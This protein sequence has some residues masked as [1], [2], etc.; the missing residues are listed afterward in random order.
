MEDVSD[1]SFRVICK[2]MGADIVYTEFIASEGIIRNAKK[3]N[4]K[5]IIDDQ[6]RPTAVQIFG[7]DFNAMIESA[8]IVE[9][10]GADILDINFGCWVKKVV[11]RE[12]GAAFLKDPERMAEL[13][14]KMADVV[15]IPLTVKT[16][17]GWD[18][19][20]IRINE[21]AKMIED[22]G[23]AALAIHCRTRSDGM[24][25]NADWSYLIDVKKNA[26]IPIILNGDV[27]DHKDAKRAFE[28][29]NCDAVMVGRGCIGYPF[30]FKE[31]K[32][33]LETGIEPSTP[34]IYLR[35]NTCLEHLKLNY[36]YKGDHGIIEF[37]K[38]YSGYL[39][40]FYEASPIRQK[41]MK[42]KQYDEVES[43]LKEY[44]RYLE[45]N[46]RLEPVSK[47]RH[48]AKLSC[49]SEAYIKKQTSE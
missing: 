7:S 21:V 24:G 11:N 20:S 9:D 47:V 43:I 46:N 4:R 36:D 28:M 40:G 37:R 10:A 41:L 3:A 22:A 12:A 19:H 18:R 27:K 39:K 13:T 33:Y 48:K 49:E 44:I 14:N 1:L 31:I 38:H 26:N 5:M 6:E 34:D 30:V 2:K 16:R 42:C 45:I 25:G 15:S 23:A 29:T 35:V 17:L 8:K 32:D